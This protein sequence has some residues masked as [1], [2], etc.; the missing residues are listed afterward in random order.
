MEVIFFAGDSMLEV[1]QRYNLYS[2]GGALPPLWGLGF[3][4]RVHAHYSA[5]QV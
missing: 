4:N 5:E 1:V 2:G 3:W